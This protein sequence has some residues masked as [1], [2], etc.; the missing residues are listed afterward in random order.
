MKIDQQIYMIAPTI[1]KLDPGKQVMMHCYDFKSQ[2][3]QNVPKYTLHVVD[4]SDKTLIA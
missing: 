4:S 2:D 1:N 3:N